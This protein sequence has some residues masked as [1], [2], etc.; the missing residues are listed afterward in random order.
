MEKAIVINSSLFVIDLLGG[1]SV[2]LRTVSCS[3][4][5]QVFLQSIG[6]RFE[7]SEYIARIHIAFC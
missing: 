1:M 4:K 7:K 3:L 6:A 2:Y 5:A